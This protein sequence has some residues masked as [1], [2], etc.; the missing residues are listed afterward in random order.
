MVKEFVTYFPS[1][2]L[3]TSVAVEDVYKWVSVML[4]TN[5]SFQTSCKENKKKTVQR[6]DY[7]YF[8]PLSNQ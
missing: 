1:H 5:S 2:G 6:Q 3:A 4:S 7:F 8:C